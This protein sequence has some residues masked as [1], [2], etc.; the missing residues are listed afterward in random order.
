MCSCL[1][2]TIW[3]HVC[4]SVQHLQGATC[5]TRGEG[6]I[7]ENDLR[8]GVDNPASEFVTSVFAALE[9]AQTQFDLSSPRTPLI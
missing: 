5:K 9:S 6:K 7:I 1:M 4:F 8:H 3:L 2:Y